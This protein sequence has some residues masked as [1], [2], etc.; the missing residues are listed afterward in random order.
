MTIQRPHSLVLLVAIGFP[1]GA[2]TDTPPKQAAPDRAAA[3]YN[4]AM[5]HLYSELASA[6]GNKGD[7]LTKAIEFYKQALKSDPAATFLSEELSD[8]YIQAGKLRDAVSEAEEALKR[9]PDDITSRRILGRIYSRLVGDPQSRGINEEMLK[10]AIEQYQKISEKLP[11]D[12]DTWLMLGRLNKIGRN[13]VDAEKAYKK[14]LESDPD[15]E[16]ALTGLA[17]LYSDLGDTPRAAEMLEKVTSKSPGLRTLTAL[18]AAYEQMREYKLASETLKKALALQPANEELKRALANNFLLADELD[19]SLKLFQE[20]VAEDPKDSQ[21]WLRISQIY[22]Q[23][24]E[25]TKAWEA[26][27]KAVELEPGSIEV[28]YNEVNIYDAQ[29]KTQEAIT[30]LKEL[31]TVTTRRTYSTA[32]RAN[33]ALLLE[34]L[35]LLYRQAEQY[36]QAVEAFRQVLE[37]DSEHEARIHAQIVE[38]YRSA[39]NYEK[40]V[41]EA[42]EALKKH[43]DD[44]TL[45]VIRANVLAESGKG[46]EAVAALKSLLDGKGDRETWLSL[47]Q[48]YEKLK[49]YQEMA[50]AIDEAEKLSKSDEEREAIHFT[51]GAMYER[52]K[53]FDLAE[54][55]F[56]K[57]LALNPNSASAL[58]YLGYMMADRNVR[59]QEAY[60]LIRKA[61]E[62]EPANGAYLDSLGWVY[63]R[64]GKFSEA[65]TTLMRALEFN[66]KDPTIHDHLGDVYMKLGKLKDAIG[67]WEISVKEWHGGPPSEFDSSEVAKIQKKLE[68][69]RVRL[70]KEGTTPSPKQQ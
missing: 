22:R 55:E 61:V 21:S 24:R 9:N 38:T 56:R 51:R 50:K 12:T 31:L 6:Y 7:Y 36:P 3:Y 20:L 57:L 18:A 15:N 16:D 10:R 30:S 11:A 42:D 53:Q 60:E 69:A 32:D 52:S 27:R 35:G 39:H 47:A 5:G 68:G 17:L 70:A 63:Y 54:G 45:K 8:L 49:N 37:F 66:S 13:S 33:R 65:E 44:R 67:Q 41:L 58:N 1:L 40:A 34:R 2:Q 62:Q 4:F 29:G 43:P 14:V 25:F 59:L 23:K 46:A 48:A 26:A 64:L 28:R 19:D